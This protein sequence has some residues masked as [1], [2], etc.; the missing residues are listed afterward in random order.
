MKEILLWL[1]LAFA[2]AMVG[3]FVVRFGLQ[4]RVRKWI[5]AGSF[6]AAMSG[7]TYCGIRAGGLI[8]SRL[9]CEVVR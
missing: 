9:S 2:S 7:S 4:L 3:H 5:V 6:L 8:G 1:T